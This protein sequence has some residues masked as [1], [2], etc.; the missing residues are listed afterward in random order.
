MNSKKLTR[1]LRNF[2]HSVRNFRDRLG[3]VGGDTGDGEIPEVRTEDIFEALSE[4]AITSDLRFSSEDGSST[5][6]QRVLR[7][8]HQTW[9]RGKAKGGQTEVLNLLNYDTIELV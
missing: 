1:K 6:I 2:N 4:A 9:V 8:E 3:T 5:T 7:I